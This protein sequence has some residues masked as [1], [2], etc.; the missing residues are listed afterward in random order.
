MRSQSRFP[1]HGLPAAAR[2]S[3]VRTWCR[4]LLPLFLLCTVPEALALPTSP[5]SLN[6]SGTEGGSNPPP[7]TISFRKGGKRS[8]DWNV[9]SGSSWLTVTP[10]SGSISSESVQLTATVNLAGLAAGTYSSSLVIGLEGFRGR[11][12][13]TTIPVT[14]TVAGT[15]SAPSISIAPTALSFSGITG[16]T[17]PAA[18]L[19]S[20]KNPSG[21]MLT[22]SANSNAGWLGLSGASG[23]TTTETDSISASVNLAGL[24]AGTYTG[25]ITV[26]AS[27]ATNTPQV[28][29]VSLTVSSAPTASPVIGLSVSSLTFTGTAGGSN[30]ALQSFTVSNTGTG[31]LTWT[32]GDNASWLTLSPVS[33]T[34]TGTV[35]ATA[36]LSGLA[37]GTYGGTVTVSATGATS[38]TLPVSLT[39]NTTTPTAGSA[40][41]TWAANTESDLAGYRIYV[42]TQSGVY[43]GPISVG[44]VTTHQLTNLSLNTTYFISI[45]AIDQAGNE[46]LHS[47]EVSKSIY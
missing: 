9:S 5:S 34:N 15:T 4:L 37:A 43:G 38:K 35:S 7:Q 46:S 11:V 13:Q 19:I 21:G 16:G 18:Q 14:L 47:A 44:N 3:P 39:V 45:T 22:W 8:K 2:P 31:T 6:F 20:L 10:P 12:N 41:L 25:A 30:P 40:T 1:E 33:G 26:S 17:S 24:A 23:T 29:P 28:I 36:N 32:A 27:G 42:G